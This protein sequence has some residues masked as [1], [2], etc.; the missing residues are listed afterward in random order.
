M[1]QRLDDGGS[2]SVREQFES[3]EWFVI[4]RVVPDSRRITDV[5]SAE[6]Q[7]LLSMASLPSETRLGTR[8]R[9]GTNVADGSFSTVTKP[10]AGP[11]MSAMPLK[12]EVKIRVFASAGKG[13]CGL[14][15]WPSA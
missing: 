3:Y 13:L 1:S 5:D 8:A 10:A 7:T 6:S 4:S 14:M 12:A 2:V 11:A 9:R 15:A